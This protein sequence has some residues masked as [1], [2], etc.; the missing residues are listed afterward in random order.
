MSVA[1]TMYNVPCPYCEEEIDEV[2]F[3]EEWADVGTCHL[4]EKRFDIVMD[5]TL[6]KKED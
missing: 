2:Y 6:L 1:C 3:N 5:I 4:C